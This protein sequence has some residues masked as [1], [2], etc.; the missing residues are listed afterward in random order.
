MGLQ[1]QDGES[2]NPA[3]KDYKDFSG[4]YYPITP[5][6]KD[7]LKFGSEGEKV[8]FLESRFRPDYSS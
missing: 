8:S 1:L 5:E 6:M 4:Q 7:D 2:G 3:I